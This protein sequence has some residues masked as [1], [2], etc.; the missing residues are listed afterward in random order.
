MDPKVWECTVVSLDE[1]LQL[2][3]FESYV[4]VLVS[5][6]YCHKLSS[7]GLFTKFEV[8]FVSEIQKK[9]FPYDCLFSMFSI[10]NTTCPDLFYDQL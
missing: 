5:N 10:Q 4:S 2:E 3:H 7:T 8:E 6:T 9:S 1:Q